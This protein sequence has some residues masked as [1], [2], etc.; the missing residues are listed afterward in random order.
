[1]TDEENTITIT[2]DDE[3]IDLDGRHAAALLLA[4]TTN[5]EITT[6]D[7]RDAAPVELPHSA[8]GRR[9]FEHLESHG[10]METWHPDERA[11]GRAIPA[12]KRAHLTRCGREFVETHRLKLETME[13]LTRE[14]EV[15]RRLLDEHRS[16]IAD[17]L[18]ALDERVER[19]EQT[20]EESRSASQSRVEELEDRVELLETRVDGAGTARNK[21][22]ERVSS[23]ET[24][25]SQHSDFIEEQGK[26]LKQLQRTVKSR[27]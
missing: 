4:D 22:S 16:E 13:P 18:D 11:D 21:L 26:T 15:V 10:L 14:A 25:V 17:E 8:Q 7:A 27:L 19:V 20:A 23:L 12:A 5:G 1:M 3:Q 2:H 24:R 9:I 6:T